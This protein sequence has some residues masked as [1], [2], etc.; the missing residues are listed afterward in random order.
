MSLRC[1]VS[2]L[3]L[4]EIDHFDLNMTVSAKCL[5]NKEDVAGQG[6]IRILGDVNPEAD[7]W[8]Q[9]M[10]QN[11]QMM[12][13]MQQQI[14]QNAQSQQQWATTMQQGQRVHQQ[15]PP[16]PVVGNPAFREYNRNN[17]PEFN[18]R[19]ETQ[20]A[21]RWIKHMEKIFCIADCTNEE[22][23]IFATNQFRGAA[24]D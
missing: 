24:E 21:K 22:K 17:P 14:Q 1:L 3:Y 12:Q 9:M 6:V 19:G 5:E 11:Q 4:V 8:E 15:H 18:G 23:V 13:L 2:L 7:M 16:P 10:Q 20:E